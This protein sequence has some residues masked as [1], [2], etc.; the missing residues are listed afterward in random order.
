[1]GEVCPITPELADICSKAAHAVGGGI[2]AVDVIEHPERGLVI[3]EINHTMEFHT[4]QPTTGVNIAGMI[5]DYTLDVA[6]NGVPSFSIN[7][8]APC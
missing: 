2:L 6:R 1:M 7:Q 4:A 8:E 3:N 5:V